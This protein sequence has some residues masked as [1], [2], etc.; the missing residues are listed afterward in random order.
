MKITVINKRRSKWKSCFVFIIFPQL[1]FVQ[2]T[3]S[4]SFSK[5]RSISINCTKL[6]GEQQLILGSIGQSSPMILTY[7]KLPLWWHFKK[8]LSTW[9]REK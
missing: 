6:E 2:N 9:T 4:N 8:K 7:K 3:F 1:H 5:F